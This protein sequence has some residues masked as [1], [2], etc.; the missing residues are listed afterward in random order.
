VRVYRELGIRSFGQVLTYRGATLAGLFTNSVFGVIL[1]SIILGFYASVDGASVRGWNQSQAVTQTWINQSLLMI[2][3]MW[4]WWEVARSI[5]T[6][7]IAMDFLKPTNFLFYWLSRDLGRA[8]AHTL[9]RGIPTFIVGNLLYNLL[10]PPTV[11]NAVAFVVSISLAVVV[12][13]GL[14]FILNVSGFWII[15][16]RG[17]NYAAMAILNLLSG[18][19]V[20]LAFFPDPVLTV[21]NLLPFRAIIMIPAEIYLGQIPILE[22][23]AIQAFWCVA[24]LAIASWLLSLGERKLVVQGG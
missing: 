11:T 5:Q 4:G 15:D 12:S 18:F 9:V 22:G 21:I 8:V 14:R 1:A 16:H 10:A 23:L 19:L 3:F 20:P 24:L 17:V 6:G 13:F 7:A 2:T